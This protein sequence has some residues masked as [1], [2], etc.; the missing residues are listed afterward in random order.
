M[1]LEWVVAFME[2]HVNRVH[3]KVAAIYMDMD[4]EK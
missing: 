2:C 3:G 4:Y 1:P